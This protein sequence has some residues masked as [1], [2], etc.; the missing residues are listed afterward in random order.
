MII[1]QDL[2]DT[3]KKLD[4]LNDKYYETENE[5]EED[6]LLLEIEKHTQYLVDSI[7]SFTNN[8][9]DKNTASEI[10]RF[11][12]EKLKYILTGGKQNATNS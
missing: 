8:N 5:V 10:V 7:V 9:I 6:S 3:L 11:Y 2:L 1:V 12:P 4:E